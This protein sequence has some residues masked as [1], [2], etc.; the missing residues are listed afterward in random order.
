MAD[1]QP[2]L[3]LARI[4][5]AAAQGI[6]LAVDTIEKP[7]RNGIHDGASILQGLWALR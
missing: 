5:L 7:Q 1:K 3:E 4:E 2:W 6:G